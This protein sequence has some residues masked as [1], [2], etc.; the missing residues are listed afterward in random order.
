[1][2]DRKDG[3]GRGFVRCLISDFG[4]ATFQSAASETVET[5]AGDHTGKEKTANQDVDEEEQYNHYQ[6][7]QNDRQGLTFEVGTRYGQ[8]R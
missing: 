2:E 6:P 5:D 8:K 1:V 7:V 3:L 4:C